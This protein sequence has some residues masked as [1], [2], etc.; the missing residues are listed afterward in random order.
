MATR[1]N[2]AIQLSPTKVLS[3][4]CHWDGY[5][6]HHLPIL[7]EHYNTKEKVLELLS[8][9]N[10]SSLRKNCSLPE[11]HSFDTPVED[12]T[13]YYGRDRGES[14]QEA[15]VLNMNNWFQQEY[16]YLFTLNDT[17]EAFN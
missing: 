8:E 11:G 10:I 7:K 13:V 12:F 5:P 9:G 17:W 6:N 3:I 2:I 4:Y 16:G 15:K 14:N 1:S